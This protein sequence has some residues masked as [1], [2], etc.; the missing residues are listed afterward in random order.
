[1]PLPER[2]AVKIST[3]AAGSISIT[4][5]VRQELPARQLVE[6]ILRV[7]GKDAAR[8]CEVLRQ[9]TVVNGAS[10]FRWSPI[11]AEPGEVAEALAA[12]PDPDPTRFF[13]PARCL[14]ARLSGGRSP[15]DFDRGAASR[16]RLFRRRSFWEVVLDIADR[17]PLTYHGYSYGDRAD[18]Y[19]AD[20]PGDAIARLRDRSGLLP[21]GSLAAAIRGSSFSRLELWVER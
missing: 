12:F 10:R 9:G 3:E 6:N 15:I 16:R 18:V 7:T 5:V 11:D 1:L 19:F 17:T 4:P 20:L 14:R 8:V 21:Y 13:D 2:I